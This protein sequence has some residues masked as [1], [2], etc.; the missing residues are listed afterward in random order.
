M[1]G[2]KLGGIVLR[3]IEDESKA[4]PSAEEIAEWLQKEMSKVQRKM[5]IALRGKPQQPPKL[6]IVAL[7]GSG[8]G[9]TSIIKRFVHNSYIEF[10]DPTIGQEIYTKGITLHG[11]EHGLQIVDTA[12]QEKFNS[13]PPN[14]LRK[15]DG[16]LLV[17]DL[18]V[19]NTL[20]EGV[21]KMLQLLENQNNDNLSIILVGNKVDA[22]G[23]KHQITRK[24]A[25]KYARQ[26]GVP[27]IETSAKTGHNIETLFEEI[28]GQIYNTL[29]LSDIEIFIALGSEKSSRVRLTENDSR[30]KSF[31]VGILD[32]LS[33]PFRR[34]WAYLR[35]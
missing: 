7:G 17:F 18:M 3:C 34:M 2:H 6:K 28:A 20:V 26:I 16:V 4:R 9:K 33:W 11:K 13:I 32:V 23:S 14:L 15:A 29:D 27:Y 8:T 22:E 24:Q 21:P 12:G 19:Q 10:D 25:K 1:G 35:N 30:V 31:C 5:D